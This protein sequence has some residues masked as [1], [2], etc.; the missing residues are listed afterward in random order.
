MAIKKLSYRDIPEPVR[1][2]RAARLIQHY[3]ALLSDPQNS[4]ELRAVYQRQLDRMTAWAT[5]SLES[6]DNQEPQ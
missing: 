5:G 1:K 4:P 6:L 2:E 3:R